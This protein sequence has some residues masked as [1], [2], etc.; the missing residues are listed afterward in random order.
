MLGD[1][2]DY[3][4][5]TLTLDDLAFVTNFFHR[6]SNFH[7][8]LLT[9]VYKRV[10]ITGPESVMATVCSKCAESPPSQVKTVHP[11]SKTLTS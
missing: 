5:N 1:V 3:T 4:D 7:L 2:T 9:R 11:S 10:K 8:S 6:C